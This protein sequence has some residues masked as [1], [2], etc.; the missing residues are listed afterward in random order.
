MEVIERPFNAD[1]GT[2]EWLIPL[3]RANAHGNIKR[4]GVGLRQ[5]QHGFKFKGHGTLPQC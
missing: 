1:E 5:S 4:S 2:P 3:V